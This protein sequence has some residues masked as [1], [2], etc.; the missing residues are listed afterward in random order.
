MASPL[1]L[2]R[3][4]VV[5]A[6]VA[7]LVAAC[8]SSPS[9]TLNVGPVQSAIEQSILKQHHINTSVRC[10]ADE[11]LKTGQQFRCVASLGAGTYDVDVVEL[12]ARGGVS[13][14][15]S[16]PLRLLDRR[17]VEIAIAAAVKHQKHLR[18]TVSCPT[19]I[20]QASGVVFTCTATTKLGSGPFEVTETNSAGHVRF[21]GQ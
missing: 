4:A 20:L 17:T 18:A 1:R 11:P 6:I 5:V 9:A 12:N 16:V 14:S 2:G 10:P 3:L 15:N 8:G 7:P 19:S 13:Y 21:V